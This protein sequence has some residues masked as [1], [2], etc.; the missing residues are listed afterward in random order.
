[1]SG[2]ALSDSE[3]DSLRIS[4]C[5]AVPSGDGEGDDEREEGQVQFALGRIVADGV[6]AS[7]TSPIARRNGSYEQHAQRRRDPG[8]RRAE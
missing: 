7:S 8:E 5:S 4:T 1:M 3:W 6:N 2:I